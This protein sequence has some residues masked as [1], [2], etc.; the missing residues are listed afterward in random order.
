CPTDAEEAAE[1][2][3]R[4]EAAPDFK[5]RY[6]PRAGI[7]ATNSELKRVH[8]LRKLR[9]RGG[10]R[11]RLAVYFKALGCNLKRALRRWQAILMPAEVAAARA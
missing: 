6:A 9:V 2:L 8:G 5:Q 10:Q 7:E 3:K 11:V 1:W 4:Q